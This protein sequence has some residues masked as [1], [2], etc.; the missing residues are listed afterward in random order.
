VV[1]QGGGLINA[2]CA[3]MANTIIPN[4]TLALSD[5]VSFKELQHFTII[6]TGKT[7]VKYNITHLPAVSVKTFAAREKFDR[8]DVTPDQDGRVAT[9]VITPVTFTLAPGAEKTVKVAFRAPKAES[10]E[11]MVY[12]GYLILV[13]LKSEFSPDLESST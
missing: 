5:S 7:A 9:A 13:S 1:H 8:P 10:A 6:N 3:V 2:Y 12:S 11:L 4:A